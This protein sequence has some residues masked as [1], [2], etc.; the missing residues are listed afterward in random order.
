M[1][2]NMILSY[3]HKLDPG[4]PIDKVATYFEVPLGYETQKNCLVV[5]CAHLEK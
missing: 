1:A 2:R 3:L 4:I 5:Q